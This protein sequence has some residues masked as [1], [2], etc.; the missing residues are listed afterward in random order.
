MALQ[1]ILG[2]SGSGKTHGIHKKIVALSRENPKK[3]FLIIVPEQFTMQT[4]RDLVAMHPGKSILNIDVL[5]FGRLSYR[6]FDETGSNPCQVLEETGKNLILRRVAEE[7]SDSL[8]VLKKNITK[9]GYIGE[10]KSL[11]SELAQYNVTPSQ[12]SEAIEKLPQGSF[13]HIGGFSGGVLRGK[14]N[15]VLT[16]YQGFQDFL[17]GKFITSE[18]ILELLADV[19]ER[20]EIIK[21]SVIVFDGFTGFTPIQNLLIKKLLVLAQDIYVTV[22]IDVREDPYRCAGVHELFAMSKKMIQSLRK[23]AEETHTQILDPVV[24]DGE[25]NGRFCASSSLRFLEQNLFRGG[26]LTYKGKGKPDIAINSLKNPREE[27]HFTA[28]EIERLVRNRGYAYRDIA[29]VCGDLPGYANYAAEVFEDYKIPLFL[30]QKTTIVLHPFVEYLRSVLEAVQRDFSRES[31]FRYLRSGLSR[32]P[33]EDVDLL[34]NYCLAAGV[35]GYK[36]W[37]DAFCY[38]PKGYEEESL[39]KLNEIR[40]EVARQFAELYPLWNRKNITVKERTLAFYRFL[41]SQ[42]IEGRLKQKELIYEAAGDLKNAKEYAQIYRIVMDLFDK[43]VELLGEE[44]ISPEEYAKILDSGFEAAKVGVIPPGYDRV[45]FG[46]IERT[47]L[48]HI[49]ILFFVGVNDGIIPKTGGADGILSQTERE[50]LG[51]MDLEL[52]PTVREKTFMQK[53]YLYLN[54]TKPSEKL[55]LSYARVNGEGKAMQSSYLIHT[56]VKMFDCLTIHE[57]DAEPFWERILTPESARSLLIEGMELAKEWKR[58]KS[59]LEMRCFAALCRWYEKQDAWR[60]EAERL[61]SA[62]RL[63]HRD[64][65][66][67]SAVTKALYGTVLESSVT[68]LEKFASCAFAHFLTYGLRLQERGESGFY[69]VDFGNVFHEALELFAEG[70]KKNNYSWFTITEEE[71]ERLLKDAMEQTIL[72]NHNVALYENAR[73]SYAK[74]RMYRILRRTVNALIYQVRKGKF[75][76][77][78]FEV[79]FSCA[80]DLKSV[81]FHLS[82]EENMHLKGRIDRIDTYESE[83]KVYVKIIDYKSGSTGFQLL[84]IY[85]GLQLQL[86]VYMNA[87]LE[88]MERRYP[89]KQAVAAGVFYYHVKDPMIESDGNLGEEALLEKIFGELKLNG[90]VNADRFVLDRFDESLAD[91]SGVNSNVIPVGLNKDGSVKKASKTLAEKDFA[92]LSSY[93]NETILHL[94]QRMMKGDIG[95]SPYALSGKTGCDYCEFHSVCHFD[96]KIKGYDFRKLKELSKEELLEEMRGV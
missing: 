21:N 11:I 16:M 64:T 58:A 13:S 40:K 83:H 5:S 8:T 71:S 37:S 80:Q 18:E 19:A 47:R 54:L 25:A 14:L 92:A 12:L 94:G 4:Q 93:V 69:A 63:T 39:L 52:A 43:L 23:M 17:A 67:S 74:E 7:K 24:C 81:R 61:F 20:S 9:M 28:R 15:D 95:V 22:T 50:L 96:A 88:I 27:L 1:L 90:I 2:N 42:D 26:K 6:I 70:I 29:V 62:A 91:G 44:A 85:H 59:D 87:A 41:C 66:I 35:R 77:D 36:K 72:S 56:I 73:S 49:K 46:D 76:P 82:E 48:D 38:L 55:Y 68:R 45:V 33:R 84:H 31:V 78:C 75:E 34:E 60:D 3:H 32:I 57:I 65:P 86:V 10:V 89:G 30:D 51:E 79:G 53:F